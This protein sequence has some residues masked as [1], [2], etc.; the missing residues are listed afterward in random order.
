MNNFDFNSLNESNGVKEFDNKIFETIIKSIPE[1]IIYPSDKFT[2]FII[3]DQHV[4]FY[5]LDILLNLNWIKNL[6]IFYTYNDIF[7]NFTRSYGISPNIELHPRTYSINSK[8]GRYVLR[9]K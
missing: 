9:T 3:N 8:N 4:Q 1:Q 6:Q 2:N 5:K 7:Y